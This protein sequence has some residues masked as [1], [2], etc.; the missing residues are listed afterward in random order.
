MAVRPF[1]VKVAE[2]VVADLKERLRRTRWPGEVPDSG[3][4]YGTNLAY[5]RE[6]VDYW[7]TDFDWRAAESRLNAW[8]QFTTEVDGL[9]IHF[10][11]IRGKGTRPLPILLIHG[12]PG[13]Y[14]EF[15]RIADLLA[16]PVAHSF[17]EDDAFDVVIPSVPGFGFSPDHGRPGVTSAVIAD[18]FSHLMT[19]VLGY[20]RFG[21]QGGDIGSMIT[22]QLA[23]RHP[24]KLVGIHLNFPGVFRPYLGDG[25]PPLTAEEQ[26]FAKAAAAWG[27]ENSGY[28]HIHGTRPQTLSYA[29]T[30]SPVGLAGWIVEKFRAWSDCGGDI[31]TRFGKDELLT[32]VMIYWVSGCINSSMRLYYEMRHNPWQPKADD[33]VGVPV[34][35]AL[36]REPPAWRPPRSW[37]E[38]TFNIERWTEMPAGGHFAAMEEPTLLADDIRAFFQ[39]LRSGAGRQS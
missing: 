25:T 27:E 18:S 36:F 4:T 31:E 23:L 13:S 22:A 15:I 2:S 14:F 39:P 11:H 33:R 34:G 28:A 24:E 12:W 38:R 37:M 10:A 30:D 20:Q 5:L 19:D 6:L 3:W 26:E 29:L 16:D 17:S 9:P 21:S 7:T 1:Q 32:N 35:Y 8:P